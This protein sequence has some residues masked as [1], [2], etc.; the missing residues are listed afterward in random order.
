MADASQQPRWHVVPDA[1]CDLLKSHD[2]RKKVELWRSTGA[3]LL[4]TR[5]IHEK[6]GK[7]KVHPSG[8][9]RAGSGLFVCASSEFVRDEAVP[10]VLLRWTND[11]VML[12]MPRV[13]WTTDANGRYITDISVDWDG[14]LKDVEQ[15]KTQSVAG[16]NVQTMMHC[17]STFAVRHITTTQPISGGTELFRSY[18]AAQWR[19]MQLINALK[20]NR[21]SALPSYGSLRFASDADDAFAYNKFMLYMWLLLYHHMMI[22]EHDEDQWMLLYGTFIADFTLSSC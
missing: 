11:V 18:G 4:F 19:Q 20:V 9:P 6:E 16:R 22:C 14:T 3:A 5:A 13:T 21:F 8:I 12:P 2:T 17:S 7:L 1:V 10:M 15:Y